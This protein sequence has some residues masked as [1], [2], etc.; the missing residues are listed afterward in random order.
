M[1]MPAQRM[2]VAEYL[3]FEERTEARHEYVDGYIYAMSGATSPHNLIVV[4]LYFHARLARPPQGCRIFMQGQKVHVASS[5]SIY[6]PDL[7]ASCDQTDAAD[8]YLERPCFVIEVLSPSTERIDR[9]EKRDD[10]RTI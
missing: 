6:Y 7:V 4:N 2:S 9:T 8:S 3:E 5:N 10:Y 1:Q